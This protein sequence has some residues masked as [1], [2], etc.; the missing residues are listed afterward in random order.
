[1]M[2][3][4]QSIRQLKEVEAWNQNVLTLPGNKKHKVQIGDLLSRNSKEGVVRGVVVRVANPLDGSDGEFVYAPR[5]LWED[6][7]V[8]S[9]TYAS[10]IAK[11]RSQYSEGSALQ[12]SQ[13]A[14]LKAIYD[15]TPWCA[16]TRCSL[17]APRERG[18]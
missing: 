14:I 9:D 6:D 18:Y 3:D 8:E 17:R 10:Q 4:I 13:D 11:M 2:T 15:A 12:L 5:I 1:M 16:A 7:T